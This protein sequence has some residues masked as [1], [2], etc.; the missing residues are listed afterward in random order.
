MTGIAEKVGVE[1]ATRAAVWIGGAAVVLFVLPKVLPWVARQVA[2][3]V[4]DLGQA[5]GQVVGSAAAAVNPT[6]TDNV[7]YRTV[8]G[9]GQGITG[10]DSFSL[11]SWLYDMTHPEDPGP[12]VLQLPPAAPVRKPQPVEV[13]PVETLWKRIAE[14][15]PGFGAM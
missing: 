11:G 2:G 15:F 7:I 12:V 8:N 10:R 6:S 5:A 14:A 9:V 4:G 3:G 1:V 13:G